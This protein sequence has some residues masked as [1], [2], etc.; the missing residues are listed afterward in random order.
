MPYESRGLRPFN[1]MDAT[2]SLLNAMVRI[3]SPR[4]PDGFNPP[5]GNV[6]LVPHGVDS[7]SIAA[8]GGTLVLSPEEYLHNTFGLYFGVHEDDWLQI[9]KAAVD[10]I[11]R[12]F[13]K[14]SDAPVNV[15][16]TVQNPRLKL[17]EV[18]MNIPIMKWLEHPEAWRWDLV[19]AGSTNSRPRPLRMPYDGCLFSIQFVLASDLTESLRVAERPWRKGSWLARVQIRV[20]AAKGIGLSPRPLTQEVRERH[21]LGDHCTSFLEFHGEISGFCFVRDLSESLTIYIDEQLLTEAAQHDNKGVPIRAAS[22]SLVN[23]WAMDTFRSLI[24]LVS[25]DDQLNDFDVD[26]PD[27]Q[28]T[29]TYQLLIRVHESADI[30]ISESLNILRDNPDKFISLV[31]GSIAMKYSDSKLIGLR[32]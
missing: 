10:D 3:Q 8:P 13:R 28:Y 23:R 32:S 6:A 17:L 9:T 7:G 27:H 24:H 22:T 11:E 26:N 1:T 2:Q 18:V 15:L 25:R 31:E 4:I 16:V 14:V 5:L 29:F 21:G 20:A 30:S 19:G 12:I